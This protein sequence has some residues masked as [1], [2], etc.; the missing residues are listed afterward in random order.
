EL[1]SE[2]GRARGARRPAVSAGVDSIGAQPERE[3]LLDLILDER[4]ERADDE[5]GATAREAGE[6]VAERLA[7]PRGH[8]DERVASR[9]D[10][11]ADGPLVGPE[12]G[13]SEALGEESVE[14]PRGDGLHPRPRECV[15]RD[16]CRGGLAAP[17]GCAL[18]DA[19][20]WLRGSIL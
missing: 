10:A 2:I 9:G 6:L 1:S 13:V 18:L 15:A 3:E 17:G 4:D 11:L 14:R 20:W 16:G 5:R 19:A 8:H 12:A 7:G